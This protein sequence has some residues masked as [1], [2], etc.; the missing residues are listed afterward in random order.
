[1][2]AVEAKGEFVEV[3]LQV[4]AAQAVIDAVTTSP[5]Q[6]DKPFS[7]ILVILIF[8]LS[9]ALSGQPS[10]DYNRFGLLEG[11]PLYETCIRKQPNAVSPAL[12]PC[13]CIALS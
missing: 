5:D 11:R 12:L 8:R 13:S 4:F 7:I 1:V 6:R 9:T 10:G 3:G 2:A